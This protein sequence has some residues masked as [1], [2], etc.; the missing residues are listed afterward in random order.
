[1]RAS[2]TKNVRQM[3]SYASQATLLP[4]FMPIFNDTGCTGAFGST[5]R[6][7]FSAGLLESICAT[8]YH[9]APLSPSPCAKISV[10]VGAEPEAGGKTMVFSSDLPDIL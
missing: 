1:M 4:T 6:T 10:A 8:S 7:C 9:P 5:N 2:D 3:G